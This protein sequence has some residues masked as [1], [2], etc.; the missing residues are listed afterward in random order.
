LDVV[1]RTGRMA[2][3]QATSAHT[4]SWRSA[5]S[6]ALDTVGPDRSCP[7]TSLGA[8]VALK[9]PRWMRGSRPSSR[10]NHF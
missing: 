4:D 5:I 8:A 9:K 10:P 6:T 1:A 2:S 3:L 7:G